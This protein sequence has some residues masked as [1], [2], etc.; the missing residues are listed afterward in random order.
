MRLEE[1]HGLDRANRYHL[2]LLHALFLD[3]INQDIRSFIERWNHHGV[4]GTTTH[5]QSPHVCKPCC[6]L[7]TPL[8]TGF[9]KDM[10]FLGQLT[11][12]VQED[13]YAHVDPKILEEFL[14]VD[15]EMSN[16]IAGTTGAGASIEDADMESEA[17][18][19]PNSSANDSDINNTDD[20]DDATLTPHELEVVSFLRQQLKLEQDKHVRHPP[21][22]V[23][24]KTCPFSDDAEET[25]FWDAFSGARNENF[26]P[27]GYGM[28]ESEWEGGS[29][30]TEQYIGS[31]RKF[32]NTLFI[33]LPTEVWFSRAVDWVV[34]LHLMNSVTNDL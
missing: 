27:S 21:V 19:T 25:S 7:L 9:D 20:I 26:V 16:Q 23:P 1:L 15:S 18:H 3:E 29:Y 11:Q 14:G 32:V 2:W 33:P 31:G 12:G 6:I 8:L 4:S 22:P 24:R 34:G 28:L 10:R 30:P 13:I 17:N 5:N